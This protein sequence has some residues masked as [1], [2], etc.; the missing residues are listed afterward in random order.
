MSS[1]SNMNCSLFYELF[2]IIHIL[3][4]LSSMNSIPY[5]I[6]MEIANNIFVWLRSRVEYVF[7]YS[8]N[9]FDKRLYATW[10]I[11]NVSFVKHFYFIPKIRIH[12]HTHTAL[13]LSCTYVGAIISILHSFHLFLTISFILSIHTCSI[14]WFIILF[15]TTITQ[16]VWRIENCMRKKKKLCWCSAISWIP[17]E[18][19]CFIL[20]FLLSWD[21]C[22][23][24]S[25]KFLTLTNN[26]NYNNNNNKDKR[27]PTFFCYCFF[28][29]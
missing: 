6:E 18:N 5:T 19:K 2:N 24:V 1:R 8:R 4:C 16:N 12:T 3:L 13:G 21:L 22:S 25:V 29:F 23:F 20:Q 17:F 26:N 7:F 14:E 9:N 15:I 10:Y 27:S 11:L 28:A